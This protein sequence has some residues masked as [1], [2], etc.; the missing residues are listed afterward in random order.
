MLASK[1]LFLKALAIP[2]ILYLSKLDF[3]KNSNTLIIDDEYVV[4]NGWV[5]LKSDV[6]A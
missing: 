3:F 5:M 1:R 2:C 4:L 6:E